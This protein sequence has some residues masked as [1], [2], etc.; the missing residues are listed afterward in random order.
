MQGF[1][2]FWSPNHISSRSQW[3]RG[4]TTHP[5]G[6]RK[7]S[8]ARKTERPRPAAFAFRCPLVVPTT[9]G[10]RPRRKASERASARADRPGRWGGAGRGGAGSRGDR[11]VPLLPWAL[12][13]EKGAIKRVNCERPCPRSE[14]GLGRR[15]PP[16]SLAATG[17]SSGTEAG[18]RGRRGPRPLRSPRGKPG[19]RSGPETPARSPP[20]RLR[21]VPYPL[22]PSRRRAPLPTPGQQQSSPPVDHAP[23]W[24]EEE[25]EPGQAPG[26]SPLRAG[27]SGPR[28]RQEGLCV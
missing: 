1:V 7:E 26:G 14:K 8:G 9:R 28:E 23:R 18:I 2:V 21:P 11:S 15:Q 25:D 19:K 17:L 12:A 4:R 24:G 5:S 10:L 22:S 27:S 3:A 20:P 13:G 6:R 16:Q